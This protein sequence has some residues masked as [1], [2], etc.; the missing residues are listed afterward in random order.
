[1]KYEDLKINEIYWTCNPSVESQSHNPD[2]PP[3]RP[4]KVMVAWDHGIVGDPCLYGYRFNETTGVKDNDTNA[5]AIVEPED[6]FESK[7]EAK[8]F[9][10]EKMMD[11]VEKLALQIKD[12]LKEMI[13]EE[14]D[15]E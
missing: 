14:D 15:N 8:T 11:R 12:I 7:G 2:A 6:L 3:R 5:K 9:Y 4:Y 13:K 10:L 1:M